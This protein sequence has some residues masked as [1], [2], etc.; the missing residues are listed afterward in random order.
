MYNQNKHI[1]ISSFFLLSILSFCCSTQ[2]PLPSDPE[3]DS[4]PLTSIGCIVLDNSGDVEK[5]G[6]DITQNINVNTQTKLEITGAGENRTGLIG[7]SLIVQQNHLNTLQ[8]NTQVSPD[9]KNQLPNKLQIIG[10]QA[11]TGITTLGSM[12]IEFTIVS[13]PISVIVNATSYWNKQHS[14]TINFVPVDPNQ[15]TPNIVSQK[16]TMIRQ[17]GQEGYVYNFSVSPANGKMIGIEY[18]QNFIEQNGSRIGTEPVLMLIP[19]GVFDCSNPAAL[20]MLIPDG[21]FTTNDL[22]AIY[23]KLDLPI[24]IHI[25]DFGTSHPP[26]LVIDYSLN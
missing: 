6:G 5:N 3:H 18:K 15:R 8:V 22:T 10:S 4:Y 9:P 24:L 16:I 20:W 26:N 7:L 1:K 2:V 17:V 25:C 12:P 23:G 21:G 19:K 13:D 11:N 14:I